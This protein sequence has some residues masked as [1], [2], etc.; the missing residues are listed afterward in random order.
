MGY[1]L[2]TL[3]MK[4]LLFILSFLVFSFA[5]FSQ[6]HAVGNQQLYKAV[7][8]V[9]NVFA[10]RSIPTANIDVWHTYTIDS[11]RSF[12]YDPSDNTSVDDSA[13]TIVIGTKRLHG[14]INDRTIHAEWFGV[15]ASSSDNSPAIQKACTWIIRHPS[16]AWT[17]KFPQGSFTMGEPIILDTFSSG[18]YQFFSIDIEGATPAKE[19]PDT[20]RTRLLLS[21]NNTF[22]FGIQRGRNIKFNNL[23]IIGQYTYPNS[24][25]NLNIGN[26]Y[27]NQW[28]DGTGRY[29]QWSP[30][31][32]ICIDFAGYIC[33]NRQSGSRRA[34]LSGTFLLLYIWNKQRRHERRRY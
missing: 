30:Y 9:A 11:L 25:T 23:A 15:Y 24:V 16:I 10:L 22:A 4:K 27:W 28:Q 7:T 6:D 1:N 14:I 26:L 13:M 2:F 8:S 3:I 33:R 5:A 17:L 21:F 31:T 32:G 18:N 12:R 19:S 20:F 34:Y 29:D